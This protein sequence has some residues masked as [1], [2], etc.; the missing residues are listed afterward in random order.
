MLCTAVLQFDIQLRTVSK[1]KLGDSIIQF[2]F[3]LA[4]YKLENILRVCTI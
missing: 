2:N 3:F 1:S 4:D